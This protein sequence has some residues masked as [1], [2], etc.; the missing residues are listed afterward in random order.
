VFL[1]TYSDATIR[2][3]QNFVKNPAV[4]KVAGNK[5]ITHICKYYYYNYF[6]LSVNKFIKQNSTSRVRYMRFYKCRRWV[7]RSSHNIC[8]IMKKTY[9]ICHIIHIMY[10]KINIYCN[11]I[12]IK[13]LWHSIFSS[14]PCSEDEIIAI[15]I[16]LKIIKTSQYNKKI[17]HI[18]SPLPDG[19]TAATTSSWIGPFRFS[20][21]DITTYSPI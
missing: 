8:N 9:N 15:V 5:R 1:K 17:Y 2:C 13:H 11:I 14:R 16:L 4:S 3:I 18:F 6:I 20:R 7:L 10:A 21:T 19:S 12:H